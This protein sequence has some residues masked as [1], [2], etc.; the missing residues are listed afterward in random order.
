MDYKD[1]MEDG[2]A[3]HFEIESY[4]LFR[5]NGSEVALQI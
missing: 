5:Q 4:E 3:H 2:I 1:K